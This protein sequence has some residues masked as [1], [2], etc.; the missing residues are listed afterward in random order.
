M[1]SN[2]NKQIGKKINKLYSKSEKLN[3]K[4]MMSDFNFEKVL[5]TYSKENKFRKYILRYFNNKSY[6]LLMKKW[7]LDQIR[8][9]L[10]REK[11]Y[12]KTQKF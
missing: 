3:L 7:D 6:K 8:Y 9:E 12:I 11:N 1:T 2:S 4:I 5:A 10:Q